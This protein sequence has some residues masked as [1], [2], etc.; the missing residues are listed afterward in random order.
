MTPASRNKLSGPKRDSAG[1]KKGSSKAKPRRSPE[2]RGPAEAP[3]LGASRE[4][5]LARAEELEALYRP[6]RE[7]GKAELSKTKSGRALLEDTRTRGAE[8]GELYEGI[9][10]GKTPLEAGHRLARQRR[11]EFFEKHQEQ[12][13][14]AFAPHAHLQPSVEAVAQI[15]RPEMSPQTSWVAE[16][17][18]AG[19][20]LLQPK[21][22][23]GGE[24][25]YSTQVLV[26]ADAV[27][28]DDL[29]TVSRGLDEPMAPQPVRECLGA[30]FPLQERRSE[31]AP[32]GFASTSANPN[33]GM[34]I[35]DGWASAV[36]F[37]PAQVTTANAWVAQDFKVPAGIRF[38]KAT[39]DYGHFIFFL[40]GVGVGLAVVSFNVAIVI[41]KG[42]GTPQ[43]REPYSISLLTVPAFGNE[44]RWHGGDETANV[45]FRRSGSSTQPEPSNGTVRV[46]VGTDAHC[47]GVGLVAWA[48]F[49][50]S[51]TVKNIC[52]TSQV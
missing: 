3:E 49:Q 31:A 4:Q 17:G 10:G 13:L 43:I 52:V 44:R 23:P 6:L 30:P 27:V 2:L 34:V 7:A 38:Y 37:I 5:A 48:E 32:M 35:A 46:W 20:M 16:T 45:E 21:S 19:S 25:A 9:V 1:K 41:D 39:V 18:S 51:V 28:P 14:D 47:V 40:T 8:L 24:R 33:S 50:T 15:L 42:D 12:F 22:V 36:P 26:P 29:G 11:E